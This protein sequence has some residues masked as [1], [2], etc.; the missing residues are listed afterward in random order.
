MTQSDDPSW[1]GNGADRYAVEAC[2]T[3]AQANRLVDEVFAA[4]EAEAT[5]DIE[6]AAVLEPSEASPLLVPYES[7]A[8]PHTVGAAAKRTL[9]VNPDVSWRDRFLMGVGIASFVLSIGLWLS[10]ARQATPV[11]TAEATTT[12]A[13]DVAFAEYLQTSLQLLSQQPTPTPSPTPTTVAQTSAPT[14]VER[15]YVPLYQPPNAAAVSLPQLPPVTTPTPPTSS[16][17]AVAP[18]T[19]PPPQHT[20]VGVLELGDRSVAL[21][22]SNGETLRLSVGDTVGNDGW[23]LV[24]IQ[25]QRA[26][27]RRQGEVRSLT[28]GQSF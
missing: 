22:Q 18:V 13:A 16:S 21:I 7:L 6:F 1:R 20:L 26:V 2:L 3:S 10:G 5:P 23:Q 11:V 12:P 8:S 28:V 27:L 24:Q 15:I 25:N 17:V 19:P 14:T 9:S 4:V